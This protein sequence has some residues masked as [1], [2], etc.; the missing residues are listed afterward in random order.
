M[1]AWQDYLKENEPRFLEEL[2]ELLRIPTIG[3]LR[4][5]APDLRRAAEWLAQRLT[6]AGL[7]NAC[8]LEIGGGPFVYGDW[9]HAGADKPTVILYGHYD[10]QP[11]DPLSE[12]VTPPFEPSLRDGCVY[13]RGAVDDK[14]QLF[15]VITAVEALLR[16]QGRLPVNVKFLLEGEEEY[17][18]PHATEGIARHRDV[19]TADLAL[20]A[21]G[22]QWSADQPQVS[23]GCRGLLV[24]RIE[25]RGPRLDGHSGQRGGSVANPLHA[26]AELVASFHRPDGSIAVEGFYDDV[27]T[28]SADQRAAIGRVPFDETKYLKSLGSPELFGEPGYTTYERLWVRPTLEINGMC[29][30][31]TGDGVKTVLPALAW[32][33]CSCRLAPD[34][35]PAAEFERIQAHVAHHMPRG[36]EVDV[37]RMPGG[38]YPYQIPADHLANRVVAE[39]LREL[40]GREPYQV[41]AGGTVPMMGIL[42]RG[43]GV[44]MASLGF[45]LP[46]QNGHAPNEFLRLSGWNRLQQAYVMAME[47]L[48]QG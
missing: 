5:H 18:S 27:V 22:G 8:P 7:E 39:V 13:A 23:L 19:L 14:G 12:W 32:A 9:Q 48:G 15:G 16:T 20:S 10:V 38:A 37:R 28:L 34:Q 25:V 41:R 36:V 6:A 33:N 31:F 26:L 43:L 29:G 44:H 47:K 30:G 24:W 42:L 21:D 2:S 45:S 35:D 4:E 17:G 11:V 3:T 1:S 40:Y 46:D